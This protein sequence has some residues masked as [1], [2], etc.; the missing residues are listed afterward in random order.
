[1]LEH[2]AIVIYSY[3]SRMSLTIQQI[4]VDAKR[5]TERLKE[6]DNTA[7]VLLNETHAI[8]KKIDAMKQYQEEVEQLNEVAHQKPHSQLIAN[9]QKENRHLREIQQE[10]RELRAALEEH[11]TALEHIMSKYRQHTTQQIYKSRINFLALQNDKYNEVISKQA[12]KIQEMAAVMD[13]AAFIDESQNNENNELMSRLKTENQGLRELLE[14]SCKFGSYG[15]TL[16]A[17]T[18]D[19]VVQTDNT[20]L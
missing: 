12:E 13:H 17:S 14:I 20:S 19:K 5:L 16:R 18:E 8:N 1:M 3:T 6:R 10:N 7:D 11:Q 4:I 9:I 2:N 15:K